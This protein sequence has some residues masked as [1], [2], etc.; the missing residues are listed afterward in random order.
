MVEDISLQNEN[1]ACE[2]KHSPA[3]V[4]DPRLSTLQ[5]TT[6]GDIQEFPDSINSCIN[7]N[8]TICIRPL[9]EQTNW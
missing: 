2:P 6:K 8:L 3:K 5:R 9:T 4:F 1:Y 7:V